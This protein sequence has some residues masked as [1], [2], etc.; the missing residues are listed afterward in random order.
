MKR[1]RPRPSRVAPGLQGL[2]AGLRSDHCGLRAAP[3]RGTVRGTGRRVTAL[4]PGLRARS[5]STTTCPR[6]SWR[7]SSWSPAWCAARVPLRLLQRLRALGGRHRDRALLG[8]VPA[9]GVAHR[10]ATRPRSSG[11]W[12]SICATAISRSSSSS[13][14]R[15]TSTRSRCRR[16]TEE[17][18]S[19]DARHERRADAGRRLGDRVGDHPH[20]RRPHACKR[21][22][23]ACA[24]VGRTLAG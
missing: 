17:G 6:L 11:C 2:R 13:G 5:G 7:A 19:R 1:R 3:A 14:T 15:S 4:A 23:S 10:P 8:D 16:S 18:P 22:A 24:R 20:A 9:V 21:R 12:R